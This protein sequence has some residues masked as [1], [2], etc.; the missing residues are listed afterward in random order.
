LP[1]S[2]M[3]PSSPPPFAPFQRRRRRRVLGKG[4]D[5]RH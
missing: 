1:F 4:D 2:S 5:L 3:A